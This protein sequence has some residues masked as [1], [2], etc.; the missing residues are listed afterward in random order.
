MLSFPGFQ[1]W[2][3]GLQWMFNLHLCLAGVLR[4]APEKEL[5]RLLSFFAMSLLIPKALLTIPGPQ[6]HAT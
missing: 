6:K 1:V 3:F 5:L 2:D 4:L